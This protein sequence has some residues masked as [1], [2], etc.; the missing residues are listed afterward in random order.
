[1]IEFIV[2]HPVQSAIILFVCFGVLSR[3][4]IFIRRRYSNFQRIESDG[5]VVTQKGST[6]EIVDDR[7]TRIV[8]EG[9]KAGKIEVNGKTVRIK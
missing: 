7:G 2:Q 1:M 6:V 5:M 4:E 3:F 8:V 9:A